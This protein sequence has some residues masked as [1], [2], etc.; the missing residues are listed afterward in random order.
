MT[1]EITLRGDV[2]PIGCVKEKILAAKRAGITDLIL[3]TENRRDVEDIEQRYLEG[4][5][6]HYIE[7][8]DEALKLALEKQERKGVEKKLAKGRKSK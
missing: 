1:G 7:R 3:C 8:M 5:K 2:T 6:F 4:L